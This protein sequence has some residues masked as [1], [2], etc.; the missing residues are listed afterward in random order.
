VAGGRRDR[1]SRRGRGLRH[2]SAAHPR[3]RGG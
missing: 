3:G 2:D 1:R